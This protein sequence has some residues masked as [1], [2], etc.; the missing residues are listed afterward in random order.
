MKPILF[1]TPM[2]R[3]L[4]N[5]KPGVWPPEPIDSGKPFKSQTRRVIKPQPYFIQS[6][7]RWKWEIPKSKIIKCE[8]VLSASREWWE[9]LHPNQYPYKP[10]DILWVRETWLWLHPHVRY[11]YKAGTVAGY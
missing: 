4:L 8:A 7:C 3:A 2:V 5:T 9:Y 1:S 10:G 6:S 11:L